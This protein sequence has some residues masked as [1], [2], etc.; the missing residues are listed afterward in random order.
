MIFFRKL[1]NQWR[2]NMRRFLLSWVGWTC[3]TFAVVNDHF[4]VLI[5]NISDNRIFSH[6]LHPTR[7][8]GLHILAWRHRQ[9]GLPYDLPQPLHPSE[10]KSQKHNSP[11]LS[12]R[13]SCK[14]IKIVA[15][16]ITHTKV[17]KIIVRRIGFLQLS[18]EKQLLLP[19]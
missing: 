10:R 9:S 15:Y 19:A 5:S 13:S 2:N 7:K 8:A 6:R 12:Y 1:M 16:Q 17:K 18:G 4:I 11:K 3:F 14:I